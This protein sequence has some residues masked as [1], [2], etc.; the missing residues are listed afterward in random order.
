MAEGIPIDA[1]L[2]TPRG[3][4]LGSLSITEEGKVSVFKGIPFALPPVGSRRWR[5]AEPTPS[6][7]GER[8]ATA[9]APACVQST[10]ETTDSFF[11][12]A[13]PPVSEDC[14]YLNVWAPEV[15][16]LTKKGEKNVASQLP[17]MVWIHGGGLIGGDTSIPMY[18]GMQ[19]AKK[20][21]VFVSIQYRLGI[22]G[23]LSH[24][25]LTAES[26]YNASGN[27]GLSDQIQALKWVQKN[28][29]AFGGDPS[30]VTVFGESAGAYSVTQL[31]A[32]PKAQ[33]LFHKAIMQ[34]TFMPAIPELN[35]SVYGLSPA[36]Q[37]GLNLAKQLKVNSL[38]ELRALPAHQVQNAANTLGFFPDVVVDNW[39]L[40][41]QLFETYDQGRQH[42]VP[43]LAGFNSGEG[44]HMAA[45]EGWHAETPES[46]EAY[47]D[48]VRSRYG[49][50]T[51][52]YL[53]Q[54][55]ADNLN[56]AVFDPIRDAFYGWPTEKIIRSASSKKTKAY[57][58]YFDHAMGWAKK[59]GMDAFHGSEVGY[60]FN[61]IP[62]FNQ[63]KF[64]N[65]SS[66]Q[67]T[68]KDSALAETM[69]DYWV[70]FAKTGIPKVDGAPFWSSYNEK[71]KNYMHFNKGQGKPKQNLLPGMYE[72]HEAIVDRRKAN[73]QSWWATEIGLLAPVLAKEEEGGK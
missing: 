43:V 59:S 4:L 64:K 7:I 63:V 51:D 22:F 31:L 53:A 65:W 8:Q 17:V 49:D 11:Y 66:Y 33:G 70:A 14:L 34:S 54:Y 23:Y 12:V 26:S 62:R 58:Y 19:L 61:H 42:D 20:G 25:E 50:L 48:D 40:K 46:E 5:P 35:K 72:L 18:D 1:P 52:D 37:I 73:N 16:H 6:W 69:S 45:Y 56:G 10:W 15:N 27:Y 41:E 57:L 38:T 39:F 24:P 9:Y 71:N 30:N 29:S 21:V 13:P 28:I 32:S 68:N 67:P 2:K 60:T 36:E 55:P 44:Y 47:V 3:I